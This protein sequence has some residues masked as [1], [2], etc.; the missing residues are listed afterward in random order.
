MFGGAGAAVSITTG[1]KIAEAVQRSKEE[2]LGPEIMNFAPKKPP[3]RLLGLGFPYDMICNLGFSVD[4]LKRSDLLRLD[5]I[6][7][8]C[9]AVPP[10]AILE[11][12]WPAIPQQEVIIFKWRHHSFPEIH[13][14]DVIS[15][16]C[17]DYRLLKRFMVKR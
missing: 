2:T 7:R 9:G 12:V 6:A 5:E 8:S 17:I 16:E 11:T 1:P 10:D 3:R 13:S 14:C 15:L 4:K